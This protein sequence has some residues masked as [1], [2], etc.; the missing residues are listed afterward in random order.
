MRCPFYSDHKMVEVHEDLFQCPLCGYGPS[1]DGYRAFWAISMV[2]QTEEGAIDAVSVRW[3]A[4]HDFYVMSTVSWC[5]DDSGRKITGTFVEGDAVILST[6][7]ELDSAPLPV[8]IR[9]KGKWDFPRGKP[10]LVPGEKPT[11]LGVWEI[12]LQAS[13]RRRSG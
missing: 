9:A 10:A 5:V 12:A 11:F 1:Q 2:E 8:I 13:R 3:D 6:K 7:E 4:Q